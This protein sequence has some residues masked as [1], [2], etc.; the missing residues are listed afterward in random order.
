MVEAGLG[1][2]CEE[3]TKTQTEVQKYVFFNNPADPC[4]H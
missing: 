1:L 2:D 4:V 3:E